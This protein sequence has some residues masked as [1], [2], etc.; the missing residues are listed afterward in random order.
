MKKKY[1]TILFFFI[2]GIFFYPLMAQQ[3]DVP[4]PVFMNFFIQPLYIPAY[5]GRDPFRPFGN[6]KR[7]PQ[8]SIAELD[9]HGV[10]ILGDTPMALFTW[11]GNATIQYTLKSRK[12]YSGAEKMIDGVVGDINDS[13]VVLTQGD[14]KVTYPRK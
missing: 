11:R 8:I 14:Q 5:H 1:T 10:I 2:F 13:E 6:L 9:Y 4:E 12:L 3:Q 7:E